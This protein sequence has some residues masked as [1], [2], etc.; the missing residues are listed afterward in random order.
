MRR[1]QRE[2]SASSQF[3]WD[4]SGEDLRHQ[5]FG[6]GGLAVQKAHLGLCKRQ[7]EC[8]SGVPGI[9]EEVVDRSLQPLGDDP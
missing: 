7:L 3:D 9:F 2:L 1:A 8:R 4:G 5:R 6:A